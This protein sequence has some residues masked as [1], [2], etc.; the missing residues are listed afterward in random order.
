MPALCVMSKVCLPLSAWAFFVRAAALLCAHWLRT[1]KAE[2][3]ALSQL[4][5]AESCLKA[6]AVAPSVV[7][8]TFQTLPTCTGRHFSENRILNQI[9]LLHWVG[10]LD[11]HLEFVFEV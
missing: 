9:S 7:A 6:I 5:I 4:V 3:G 10:Q 8:D 2:V 11:F 1:L